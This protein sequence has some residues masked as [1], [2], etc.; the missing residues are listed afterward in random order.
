MSRTPAE[1]MVRSFIAAIAATVLALPI[2]VIAAET[3]ASPKTPAAAPRIGLA[4][5]GGGA[6]GLAHVGVLKVLEELRVPVH[7]V[8]GASIGAIVGGSFASGVPP[9]R[10]EDT[11][12]KTNWSEVFT[13]RPPRAEISSRRKQDDYKTLFAPEFGVKESGLVLPKG[14]LAGVSIEGYFRGLTETAV[15]IDDFQ[16]LPVPF[17]AMATDIETGESVV[18][19]RGNL[20][21][22]M[23]ASMAVPGA[24]APV[25]IGGRLLVDGGIANNLP[26][27]EA[28]KL[29]AEVVI[30][31][32]ISTPPLTREQ[33]TS[34]LSVSVQLLN[35]LGKQTVDRQLAG[36]GPRDVLIAPDLGD[37]SAGSFE[38]SAEA[39]RIGEAA[40]RAMAEQL[41]RYSL[42]PEQYVALRDRQ[43]REPK[44]LGTVGEIRFEGLERTNPEVLR[45]LVQSKP[46]EPLTEE[47]I[48]TDLRRIYGRGDFESIDYRIMEEPGTRVMVIQP[49]EKSWG[50][51]YLRFG[52]GL[53]SDF[54]GENPFSALVSY[55][56]TWL[57]RLGGEWLNEVQVGRVS[58]LFSEF[59]QPVDERGR[60]FVAPY[61][62]ISQT[63]RPVFVGEER[64]AQYNVDEGRVG[65]DAGVVIS[66]LGEARIGALWRHVKAKVETGSPVLPTQEE[67]TA[68]PRLRFIVD[69][70]D[71]AFF[72]RSGYSAAVSAY[73]ADESFGSDRNY[74]RLEGQLQGAMSLGAHTLNLT[75]SGGTDLNT[76]MPAYE[77]FTLGG[78]LRLSGYRIDEFSGRQMAFGR[79]MYYQRAV[80]LPD[81]LGS[82]VYAGAS[83]EAGQMSKRFDGTSPQGTIWSGSVFLGADT[84]LGPAYF[85]LGAGEGGR[86]SLYLLVGVP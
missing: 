60:T 21:Q 17:R 29:C 42:P 5:S 20:A 9:G 28:R 72:A 41:K 23:R 62:S 8:T 79:L 52:I 86:W 58:Q 75:A 54:H 1:T 33:I 45:S 47:K 38:R 57:N 78:P 61:G 44:G 70:L 85:G 83:L 34:A 39:I 56:K 7:C 69:Q 59:Y 74:K 73:A 65:L 27:D 14:I 46:G 25:E 16:K 10:L 63:T 19:D 12:V 82:G 4:L 15:G 30:A 32:N 2:S 49:R 55:R 43:I 84:F 80:H 40:A 26:I 77:T 64:V 81:L 6:R 66:T 36:M 11:V 13:D 48:G 67:T 3:T 53:A 37:I 50:P 76:D 35:F 51:D 22:A 31:V 71:H 24:M 68:G 18:L